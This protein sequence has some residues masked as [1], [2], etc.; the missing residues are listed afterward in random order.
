MTQWTT[1]SILAAV[2]S[3]R[4]VGVLATMLVLSVALLIGIRVPQGS[5]GQAVPVARTG[6]VVSSEG[7][8]PIRFGAPKQRV[9]R[10]AGKPDFTSPPV[11]GYPVP[12][13]GVNT[14]VIGYECKGISGHSCHTLYAFADGK[15]VNFST[16]SARFMTVHGARAGMDDELAARLE[17]DLALVYYCPSWRG[18][19][20]PLLLANAM[21]GRLWSLY[22]RRPDTP[23]AFAPAC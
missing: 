3:K 6:I 22:A 15:F 19:R 5:A 13:H 12:T 4:R 14:F 18:K 7:V 2:P 9:V 16:N 20:I 23:S 10:W 21:D 11:N 8:G 17:P 1:L